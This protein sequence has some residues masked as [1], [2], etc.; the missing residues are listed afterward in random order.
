MT[1]GGIFA[2]PAGTSPNQPEC[3][4]AFTK[5]MAVIGTSFRLGVA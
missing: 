3:A 4:F 2:M 1:L 5:K